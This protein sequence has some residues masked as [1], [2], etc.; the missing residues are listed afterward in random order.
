MWRS[1]Y[2]GCWEFLNKETLWAKNLVVLTETFYC[3][4]CLE[5][6]WAVKHRHRSVT[7]KG[8]AMV[9]LNQGGCYLC[10]VLES[11]GFTIFW[12]YPLQVGFGRHLTTPFDV[13]N[14]IKSSLQ[15]MEEMHNLAVCRATAPLHMRRIWTYSIPTCA[16]HYLIAWNQDFV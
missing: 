9:G 16:G 6:C 7:R 12:Q 10:M 4:T 5:Y 15:R 2:L 1:W 8:L 3:Y 13:C 14:S 11:Y